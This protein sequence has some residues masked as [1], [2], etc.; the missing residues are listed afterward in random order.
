MEDYYVSNLDEDIKS[1]AYNTG[2]VFGENKSQA[3]AGEFSAGFGDI[4]LKKGSEP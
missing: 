2:I 1:V 4:V 3:G